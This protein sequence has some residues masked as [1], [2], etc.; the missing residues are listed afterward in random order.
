MT[1]DQSRF[2]VL[3]IIVPCLNEAEGIGDTLRALQPLRKRGSELIVVDGGSRDGTAELAAPWADMVLFAAR[4]RACQMNAGARNARGGIL[5]FLHADSVLPLQADALIVDGLNRTRRNWGR[6]DARIA[7]SHP[8]LRAVELLMNV[9]SRWTGIATGDQG[10]FVT[11]SLF[12]A[13]GGYP[14]IAFME[15]IAL[16]KRLKRFGAPLCLR[17]RIVT[18]A[19][20]RDEIDKG[21]GNQH[22]R[23]EG[24][25]GV[26]AVMQPE[27]RGAAKE[28]REEGQDAHD[29]DHRRFPWQSGHRPNSSRRWL[30]MR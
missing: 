28:G 13:V 6:F 1:G 9:R 21:G 10:I 4:G 14:E 5:L 30:S 22:T 25:D 2:A 29:P 3:S 19:Q 8:L 12:T 11:R 20:L 27:H 15:D 24:H 7:G 26:Q 23:G 16:T 18:S 17:H